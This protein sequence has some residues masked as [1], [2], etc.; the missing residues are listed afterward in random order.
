MHFSTAQREAERTAGIAPRGASQSRPPAE[1]RGETRKRSFRPGVGSALRLMALISRRLISFELTSGGAFLPRDALAKRDVG[2]SLSSPDC[3]P[4]CGRRGRTPICRQTLQRVP[5]F[6]H[7]DTRRAGYGACT[8][9]A[10]L[11]PGKASA[12]IDAKAKMLATRALGSVSHSAKITHHQN[13]SLPTTP[14][15]N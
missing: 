7:C 10:T 2:S 9:L 15:S 8:E 13:A 1:E 6:S 4:F 14:H 3:P 5:C 12:K 11:P